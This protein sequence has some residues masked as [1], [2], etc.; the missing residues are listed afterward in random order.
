M[1]AKREHDAQSAVDQFLKILR[2]RRSRRFGLGMNMATGPMA[3]QSQHPGV[4][5]SEEERALLVFAA[6]GVTGYALADL[7]YERGQGGTIM[8]RLLGRTIPSGDAAQTVALIVMNQ[9]ATYYIKRPQDFEPSEIPELATMAERG[10]YVD[11]YRRSRV[12][13]KDGRDQPPMDPLFNLNCN[14]WSLYDPAATYFLPIN[15]LTWI[16]INGLLEMLNEDN[17]VFIVDE[18]NGFRP[19]GLRRFAKSRGGHLNDDPSEGRVATIQQIEAL[20]TEVVTV[21]QGMMLQNIALMVQA[22]GLGGFPHWAAHP[23]GWFQTLGFRMGE[24]RSSRYLGMGSVYSFLA[25]L[26]GRDPT[27]PY[28]LGLEHDG[29]PLLSAMC[30]PYY[31]S[32]EAAVRALVDAKVGPQGIFRGGAKHSAWRDAT[33]VAEAAPAPSESN[34]EAVISYCGYVFSRYGRFPAYSP[35]MRTV[36]G[37]QVNHVDLEFYE[38][39]YRSEAISESQREHMRCWHD[40]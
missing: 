15:E 2:E 16:Y 30:P 28:V 27:V 12:K 13:I 33:T 10:D 4:P 24:M 39:F 19:A 17:G 40:V 23:F 34:I 37:F 26:L 6:C 1:T 25:R 3:H 14:Q 18:R 38:R 5:L 20:V 31:P 9:E 29:A 8:S 32:M 22:M 11:L 21:E 7:M 35:A 36:L